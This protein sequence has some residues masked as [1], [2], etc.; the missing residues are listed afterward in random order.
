MEYAERWANAGKLVIVAALDG[1]YQRKPFPAVVALLPLAEQICKL[2]AVCMVCHRT[3]SF[4]WRTAPDTKVEVRP[5]PYALRPHLKTVSRY[6]HHNMVNADSCLAV[7]EKKPADI[8]L[9]YRCS[10][11]WL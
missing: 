11:S 1:T 3:A 4:T 10:I 2:T 8:L 5:N 6:M 7:I 9:Q